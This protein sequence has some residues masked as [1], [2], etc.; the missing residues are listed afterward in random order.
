M[1]FSD[2]KKS[3]AAM[4]FLMTYGWALL[5]V[6]IAIAALAYFGL[7]NP[8]RFLPEKCEIAPGITCMDF[9]ALTDDEDESDALDGNPETGLWSND[10]I[11]ILINNGLG[12]I[13]RNVG[14][15]ITECEYR[16]YGISNETGYKFDVGTVPEGST[17]KIS[18]DCKGMQAN[19]LFKSDLIFEYTTRTNGETL[20]HTK[21][22]YL[23]VNVDYKEP[24]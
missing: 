10:T 19:S 23:A 3:Q 16:S 4:E 9:N 13:I 22:G 11:T 20:N 1:K 24:Q 7:L 14:I 18:V 8:S 12:Q 6:L 15:N 21:K 17:M 5:V 2:K